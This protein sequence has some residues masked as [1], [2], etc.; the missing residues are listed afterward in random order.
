MFKEYFE[1]CEIG[2]CV[3]TPGRTIT[4][5]DVVM[6]AALTGDWNSIHVDKEFA[7]TSPFGQRIAHGMLGMV[8]GTALLGRLGWFTLWPESMMAVTA[9]NKV[10]FAAPVL[11]GDT[12]CLEAEIVEKRLMPGASRGLITTRMQIQNQRNE[13]V[14]T[15][16]VQI[17]A[18]CRPQQGS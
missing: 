2:Q 1:D 8:A 10:R 3:R 7:R 17:I 13:P 12:I 6:F 18:G 11:I 5:A 15:L 9:L 16:R 4:E 14:I